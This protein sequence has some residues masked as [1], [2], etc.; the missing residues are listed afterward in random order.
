MYQIKN[1]EIV[2]ITDEN[3]SHYVYNKDFNRFMCNDTKC[4]LKKRFCKHCLQ[5][6]NSESV[7]IEHKKIT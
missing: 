3:K 6:F 5:C 4:K 7:L 2:L 1:S